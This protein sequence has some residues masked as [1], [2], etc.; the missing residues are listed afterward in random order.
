MQ[1]AECLLVGGGILVLFLSKYLQFSV[2]A[3]VYAVSPYFFDYLVAGRG[4]NRPP[5]F[6]VSFSAL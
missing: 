5:T 4:W 1:Y 3:A 6:S 2:F